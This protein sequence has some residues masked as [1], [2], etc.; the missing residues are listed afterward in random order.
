MKKSQVK[1]SLHPNNLHQGQYDL[2]ALCGALPELSTH[3]FENAYGN[4]S[5][6]FADAEAVKSLNHALLVHFYQIKFW[7]IPAGFLCPPVPGRADY[8]HYAADLLAQSN[9]G[10]HP[11]GSKFKVLDIGCGANLIYPILGNAIFGWKFIGAELNPI[12]I[13]SARK[14][15]DENPHLKGKIEVIAQTGTNHIFQNII[16]ANDFFDLTIC[17]PPFHDSAESA[18]VGS[19]R[20]LSNLAEKR[21]KK[22][23]LNFGGQDA[24]LWCP[25]GE[26]AFIQK[27]VAESVKF[28][29]QVFWFTSLLSKSENLKAIQEAVKKVGAIEFKIIPMAQ[30][31]KKSRFVAWTFLDLK[32]QENWRK[33]RWA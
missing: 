30:G 20:K 27:M 10:K 4:L 11:D 21:V 31:N 1:S 19:I 14:I 24:E 12:A 8:I 25:G 3:V 17:N 33:F 2:E 7:D 28:R 26:V 13:H 18:A 16:Q 32:Q 22:V 15:I 9:S 23:N 6:N 29:N 5:I